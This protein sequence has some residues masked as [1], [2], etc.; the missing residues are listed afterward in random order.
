MKNK[1]SIITISLLIFFLTNCKEEFLVRENQ[2]LLTIGTFYKTANDFQLAMN[3]CYGPLMGPGMFGNRYHYFFNSFDDRILFETTNLDRLQVSSTFPGM[4]RYDNPWVYLYLGLYRTSK[5]I[6]QLEEKGMSNIEDITEDKYK[7]LMAEAKGLRA[8]YYFYLVVIYDQPMFYNE[9]TLPDDVLADLGNGERTEFWDQLTKDLED[10][11]PELPLRSEQAYEDIGRVNKG[12]A[13][14]LLGKAMLFKHYYYHARFGNKGSAED[15]ADLNKAKQAFLDLMNSNEYSLVMPQEPK[16]RKDYLYAL[17]SNSS[18]IDLASENNE[19]KSENNQESIWEVMFTN[20]PIYL[21]DWWL[22]GWRCAGA[23]NAQWYG[24]HKNS[25]RNHEFNPSLYFAFETGG[26]PEGFEK[27]PRCY[28]TMYLDGDTLDFRPESQ[29]YNKKFMTFVND[30]GIAI[31]RKLTVPNGTNAP[32]KSMSCGLKKYFHPIFDGGPYPPGNDPTNRRII[33]YADVLLMYAEVMYHLGDDGSGLNALNQVRQRV[34][35]PTITELTKDAIIHERDVELAAEGHRWFDLVRW[36]FDPEWKIDWND[37]D[38]GIN[39][40][41]P[42][43]PFVEG[44]HEFMPIPLDEIDING[45]KLK[46]NP[47]Y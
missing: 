39:G 10:A 18:F 28:A 16:T 46:Q 42:V 4:S 27:D 35:M 7:T 43:N 30:K 11:I 19:Y 36:S 29:F 8:I 5:L 44:K 12:A 26:A 9:E 22:P 31:G 23:L 15:V 3:S 24:P 6:Q 45:G 14:A 20:G 37:I 25:Y 40:D 33:R 38:W 2:N 1:F 41:T 17:L 34:D 21:D 47:G 32:D 13:Q